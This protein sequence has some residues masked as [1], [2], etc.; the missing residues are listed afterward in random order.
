M[1]ETQFDNGLLMDD[2]APAPDP[3]P[4]SPDEFIAW[5]TQAPNIA[6]DLTEDERNKIA[7]QAV[8]DWRLDRDSMADWLAKAEK[9]IGLATLVKEKKDYP[10]E[11]AANVK[12]PLITSAAL[13]FNAR[14]Y[15][16]IVPDDRVVK[17]KVWGRDPDGTKAARGDRVS[18]FMSFQL[19]T[20]IEEWE[21]ETDKLLVVLPIV[22]DVYRKWW[23]DEVEGRPRCRLVEPGKLIVN[24]KAKTIADAPRLTEELPTW[25]N[26]SETRTQKTQ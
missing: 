12:Y 2:A 22:G 23:F 10:F 14:A 18:E 26:H 3:E 13:Q 7:R 21:S 20:K 4:V 9:A 8:D 6:V 25:K 11:N 15:P 17:A 24:S 16:A 19:S 5:V 1:D